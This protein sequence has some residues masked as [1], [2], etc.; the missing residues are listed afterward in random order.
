MTQTRSSA[1]VV[2]IGLLVTT[3]A[4]IGLRWPPMEKAP[5][6]VAYGFYTLLWPGIQIHGPH[7]GYGDWR[8]PV[9]VIVASTLCWSGLVVVAITVFR[10]LHTR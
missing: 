5:L 3:V 6:A 10:R 1:I 2:A 9:I 8:D 4:Q 7:G